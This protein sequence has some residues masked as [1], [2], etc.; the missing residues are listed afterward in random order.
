MGYLPN[1]KDF[2]VDYDNDAELMI[3]DLEFLEDDLDSELQMKLQLVK[4][5]NLRL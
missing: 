1:R 5:Y 3:S 2:D 4:L